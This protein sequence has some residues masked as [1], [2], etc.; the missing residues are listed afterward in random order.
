MPDML[1]GVFNLLF[2]C[3]FISTIF[4]NLHVNPH[5]YLMLNQK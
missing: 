3:P 4:Y 2:R 1:D 5:G